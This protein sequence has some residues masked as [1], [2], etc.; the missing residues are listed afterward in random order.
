MKLREVDLNLL[1]AL[2]ALIRERH[3]SR[4]AEQLDISQSSMSLALARLR[5]LFHDPLLVKANNRLEPTARAQELAPSVKQLLRGIDQLIHEQAPFEPLQAHETITMIVTDYVEF[6]LMPE[7]MA[8]LEREA[9]GIVLRI[10]GPNP[11]RLGEVMSTGQVDLALSYFPNPPD[12]LR[13][14]P[15]FE[16]RMVGI[17]RLGHPML[18]SAVAAERL[19][20]SVT[21][22]S[23]PAKRRFTVRCSMK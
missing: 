4:A 2:D 5:T 20:D 19:F 14:R 15:L 12:N 3:V 10:L 8:T 1:V 7:L 13:T 17:A 22:R 6:V 21:S 16:D 11:K 9:P 18:E 23:N